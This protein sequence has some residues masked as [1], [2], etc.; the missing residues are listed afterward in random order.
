MFD[1][2]TL[3]QFADEVKK[4][5]ENIINQFDN[6]EEK[7]NLQ[8]GETSIS[9]NIGTMKLCLSIRGLKIRGSLPKYLYGNNIYN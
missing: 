9:G 5:N 4:D 8:T 7:V 1:K 2:V 6:A 3:F